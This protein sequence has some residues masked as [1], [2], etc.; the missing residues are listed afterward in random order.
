M[1]R[2]RERGTMSRALANDPP[3]HDPE[4]AEPVAPPSTPPSPR[5]EGPTRR[6]RFDRD[7]WV[8]EPDDDGFVLG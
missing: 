2:E 5:S 7:H 4:P 8:G 1:Y 6:W 3:K